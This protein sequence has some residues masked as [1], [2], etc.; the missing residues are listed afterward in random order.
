M[1]KLVMLAISLLLMCSLCILPAYAAEAELSTTQTIDVS[2]MEEENARWIANVGGGSFDLADLAGAQIEDAEVGNGKAISMESSAERD[3]A[4]MYYIPNGMNVGWDQENG[5]LSMW[6]YV[7]DLDYTNYSDWTEIDIGSGSWLGSN[8]I[9]WNLKNIELK[10]GW[11][12]LQ[13]NVKSAVVENGTIDFSNIRWIRF[14][15]TT[16]PD[17]ITFKIGTITFSG[18]PELTKMPKQPWTPSEDAPAPVVP[19]APVTPE[20]PAEDSYTSSCNVNMDE[21]WRTSWATE[22]AKRDEN[23]ALV[24]TEDHMIMKYDWWGGMNTG[25]NYNNGILKMDISAPNK[26][27]WINIKIGDGEWG[28]WD[29]GTHLFLEL[30]FAALGESQSASGY[31]F[32]LSKAIKKGDGE[33]DFSKIS[34]I[35]I[36][37]S[38]SDVA[39]DNVEFGTREQSETTETL[40]APEENTEVET[41]A[42]TVEEPVAVESAEQEPFEED[43]FEDEPVQEVEE[44]PQEVA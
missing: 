20:N 12:H 33:V 43:P 26:T 6:L 13:L 4:L 30:G 41:L 10:E 16:L 19:S 27:G 18:N 17:G 9:Y 35:L 5:V 11:N 24:T 39:I 25:V 36:I 34:Y 1:K 23:G 2:T 28:Q 38:D 22:T 29:N 3:Y 32:D 37:S 8:N 7:S 44:I 40:T 21:N 42:K 15:A 14:C 31:E